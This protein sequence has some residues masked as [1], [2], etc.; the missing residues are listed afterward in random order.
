MPRTSSCSLQCCTAQPGGGTSLTQVSIQGLAATNQPCRNLP[1]DTAICSSGGAGCRSARR[2]LVHSCSIQH[3][4]PASSIQHSAPASCS[5]TLLQHPA[6][7]APL[8]SFSV[9]VFSL[10][11]PGLC[12]SH[13]SA[14]AVLWQCWFVQQDCCSCTCPYVLSCKLSRGGALPL[15][16]LMAGC[17]FTLAPWHQQ[18]ATAIPFWQLIMLMTHCC[19]S[20]QLPQWAGRGCHRE[21]AITAAG[22]F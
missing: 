22:G 9:Q 7:L 20:C 1:G 16:R 19:C 10:A 14:A 12:F 2:L 4:A 17:E 13:S 18:V 6:W 5:S 8:K 15:F 11:Q 3:P 21:G